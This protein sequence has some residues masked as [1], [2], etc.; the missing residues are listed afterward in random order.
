MSLLIFRASGDV[1]RVPVPATYLNRELVPGSPTSA[2]A[3][4]A[5]SPAS[6]NAGVATSGPSSPLAQ[7]HEQ[8]SGASGTTTETTGQVVE[9]DDHHAVTGLSSSSS[10]S[11]SSKAGAA[12]NDVAVADYNAKTND[13]VNNNEKQKAGSISTS[14]Q[15]S[16]D[17]DTGNNKQAAQKKLNKD[18]GG[19]SPRASS[20]SPTKG[21]GFATSSPSARKKTS[22]SQIRASS[23]SRAEGTSSSRRNQGNLSSPSSRDTSSRRDREQIESDSW[24]Q[25]Q[26]SRS[27]LHRT[28]RAFVENYWSRFDHSKSDTDGENNLKRLPGM[29]SSR[30]NTTAGNKAVDVDSQVVTGGLGGAPTSSLLGSEVQV[31]D[32]DDG[33][34]SRD[35]HVED[36]DSS[37]APGRAGGPRR[38]LVEQKQREATSD[39]ELDVRAGGRSGPQQVEFINELNLRYNTRLYNNPANIAGISK[40][41]MREI[42]LLQRS[43]NG[44]ASSSGTEDHDVGTGTGTDK[45]K[46]T[47][48]TTLNKMKKDKEG[49]G[50]VSEDLQE[51]EGQ[52]QEASSSASSKKKSFAVISSSNAS[53]SSSVHSTPRGILD[54][55]PGIDGPPQLV[56]TGAGPGPLVVLGGNNENLLVQRFGQNRGGHLETD[57]EEQD[58]DVDHEI[59]VA[60]DAR[61][62]AGAAGLIEQAL[63]PRI[64]PP[65]AGAPLNLGNNQVDY[66]GIIVNAATG[67]AAGPFGIHRTGGPEAPGSSPSHHLKRDDDEDQLHRRKHSTE[68]ISMPWSTKLDE[69]DDF[70]PTNPGGGSSSS[71]QI[72]GSSPTGGSAASPIVGDARPAPADAAAT[73]DVDWEAGGF[74]FQP[75]QRASTLPEHD[76]PLQLPHGTTPDV[77]L[78]QENGG[79]SVANYKNVDHS[80][81]TTA[82]GAGAHAAKAVQWGDEVDCIGDFGQQ[83]GAAGY[84]DNPY[85]EAHFEEST[86]PDANECTLTV[87][88]ARFLVAQALSHFDGRKVPVNLC[89]LIDMDSDEGHVMT[90]QELIRDYNFTALLVI[91]TKDYLQDGKY[92]SLAAALLHEEDLE[93]SYEIVYQMSEE[94]LNQ[95]TT[96]DKD[97]QTHI[98]YDVTRNTKTPLAKTYQALAIVDSGRFR[99]PPCDLTHGRDGYYDNI[100]VAIIRVLGWSQPTGALG[101]RLVRIARLILDSPYTNKQD[102]LVNKLSDVNETALMLAVRCRNFALFKLILEFAM[103]HDCASELVSIRESIGGHE[104]AFLFAAK[105]GCPDIFQFML[106]NAKRFS[107]DINQ[108]SEYGL[109]AFLFAASNNQV[110]ICKML[111]EEPGFT[112]VNDKCRDGCNAFLYACSHYGS[113][114]MCRLLLE[115]KVRV[116]APPIVQKAEQGGPATATSPTSEPGRGAEGTTGVLGLGGGNRG[117]NTRTSTNGLDLVADLA[118]AMGATT[119]GNATRGVVADTIFEQ[120]PTGAT[121]AAATRNLHEGAPAPRPPG[122]H[123]DVEAQHVDS[124]TGQEGALHNGSTSSSATP[125]SQ[126]LVGAT[127]TA[128]RPPSIDPTTST[129]PSDFSKLKNTDERL[130]PDDVEAS[131]ELSGVSAEHQNKQ[132]QVLPLPIPPE[133]EDSDI[134]SK[135]SGSSGKQTSGSSASCSGDHP[136]MPGIELPLEDPTFSAFATPTRAPR[137][138][139]GAGGR[140]NNIGGGGLLVLAGPS[141]PEVEVIKLSSKN[142]EAGG[143]APPGLIGSDGVAAMSSTSSE[144]VDLPDDVNADPPPPFMSEEQVAFEDDAEFEY[145]PDLEDLQFYAATMGIAP[146][147]RGNQALLDD[148]DAIVHGRAAGRRAMARAQ[149]AGAAHQRR[150]ID[151]TGAGAE[152][153]EMNEGNGNVTTTT[154]TAVPVVTGRAAP[155]PPA[156]IDEPNAAMNQLDYDVDDEVGATPVALQGSFAP[157]RGFPD[158]RDLRARRERAQ[159]RLVRALGQQQDGGAG[160]PQVGAPPDEGGVDN[161]ADA[162][163]TTAAPG[164]PA[165]QAPVPMELLHDDGHGNSSAC[166]DVG[167]GERDRSGESMEAPMGSG[168]RIREQA[169]AGGSASSGSEPSAGVAMRHHDVREAMM[170]ADLEEMRN[171]N[172]NAN[173]A[174]PSG[175]VASTPP[176]HPIGAAP[177]PAGAE[178][179]V[180]GGGS[181][182][183]MLSTYRTPEANFREARWRKR[184]MWDYERG[185]Y[186]GLDHAGSRAP[187]MEDVEPSSSSSATRPSPP[188][189]RPSHQAWSPADVSG[190]PTSTNPTSVNTGDGGASS[191]S[192][193]APPQGQQQ[194]EEPLPPQP[195]VLQQQTVL[196]R[197]RLLPPP[198]RTTS[199]GARD[200]TT[201][202]LDGVP[203]AQHGGSPVRRAVA[204]Q[205]AAAAKEEAERVLGGDVNSNY[206]ETITSSAGEEVAAPEQEAAAAVPTATRQQDPPGAAPAAATASI[207][208]SPLAG[209]AGG[210]PTTSSSGEENLSEVSMQGLPMATA[211]AHNNFARLARP[212]L[213][214]G[215]ALDAE[216]ERPDVVPPRPG[217]GVAEVQT[218]DVGEE[219]AAGPLLDNAADAQMN[220]Q[221]NI[222]VVA[223]A[224]DVPIV[225]GG[226][227]AANRARNAEDNLDIMMNNFLRNR[228]AGRAGINN[229]NGRNGN[230]NNNQDEGLQQ[231]RYKVVRCNF[232]NKFTGFEAVDQDGRNGFL[233]AIRSGYGGA[234]RKLLQYLIKHSD[235]F[236][237]GFL[238][239][240]D[241]DGNNSFHQ[242]IY[243]CSIETV[244]LLLHHKHKFKKGFI[245]VKNKAG[246]NA[247]LLAA[248]FSEPITR[249]L[250]EEEEFQFIDSS[251]GKMTSSSSSSSTTTTGTTGASRSSVEQEKSSSS[252][253]SS[254]PSPDLQASTRTTT[255]V[256]NEVNKEGVNAFLRAASMGRLDICRLLYNHRAFQ[257]EGINEVDRHGNNA[258][259]LAAGYGNI[260]ICNF[261]LNGEARD[262]FTGSINC[263]NKR[264]DTMLIVAAENGYAEF[265]RSLS[266]DPRF[267]MH[268]HQNNDGQTALLA[269]AKRGYVGVCDFFVS[270]DK[271]RLELEIADRFGNNAFLYAAASFRFAE[272]LERVFFNIVDPRNNGGMNDHD[273]LR[274]DND[275][276]NNRGGLAGVVGAADLD[277]MNRGGGGSN[278][279]FL[280]SVAHVHHPKVKVQSEHLQDPSLKFNL[281]FYQAVNHEG[282]NALHLGAAD[283]ALHI[284]RFLL[285]KAAILGLSKGTRDGHGNTPYMLLKEMMIKNRWDKNALYVDF[286]RELATSTD[287]D[288]LLDGGLASS[289]SSASSASGSSSQD[290]LGTR[291]AGVEALFTTGERGQGRDAGVDTYEGMGEL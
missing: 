49:T 45:E 184:Q 275:N 110:D 30:F 20:S 77:E 59:A 130:L 31:Q 206:P 138:M 270:S 150:G 121:A 28:Q 94:E 256:A 265:C 217:Q 14:G 180:L 236:G 160:G 285:R 36:V 32:V 283:G 279:N 62:A 192:S 135:K 281:S 113:L 128:R 142:T 262:V 26:L 16:V 237:P 107:I 123:G 228:G 67:Q 43:A 6:P 259:L 12:G 96:F 18:K 189:T 115:G 95:Y 105:E 71:T 177:P 205:N 101:D 224:V 56:G 287:E 148:A 82:R 103:R 169:A 197:E 97:V 158:E 10:A 1:M 264:G 248:S 233:R 106:K 225:V 85:D 250:L 147:D 58:V 126:D 141:A 238:D 178:G 157:F 118:N 5:S 21:L 161:H 172:R 81:F 93:T 151:T 79:R 247:L 209:V 153:V 235:K 144:T 53:G 254:K 51:V 42:T 167:Q 257:K 260:G 282:R 29:L 72:P 27:L 249:M 2:P 240:C 244:E 222:N 134:E 239:A 195:I 273:I 109:S 61:R 179:L 190:V 137:T 202:W 268:F 183:L 74:P 220:N 22:T 252:S 48:S 124:T 136:T 83:Q 204:E 120:V 185:E 50:V 87:R 23:S 186:A 163:G 266:A 44:S 78:G 60:D 114:Q 154:S 246:N 122:M 8:A 267:G 15:K 193:T 274:G 68:A 219:A 112:G 242:A 271:Y 263:T 214:G 188:E 173:G 203:I 19:P 46:E 63:P 69:D 13:Q 117:T 131:R 24:M 229:L 187:P 291:A 55:A 139:G 25:R 108:K 232:V 159:E 156:E 223:A 280:A 66:G 34:A 218:H 175:G 127:S 255:C 91:Q 221:E 17:H 245:S 39:P 288:D 168:L 277:G 208:S 198:S 70:P 201:Q 76:G 166:P 261:L 289:A 52:R 170:L 92:E 278:P 207:T 100:L 98:L 75:T 251:K 111:M 231:R 226:A 216:D 230:N 176:P 125:S 286:L 64:P 41:R 191:S 194:T 116:P 129:E 290:P 80:E 164:G 165:Q 269:A 145:S 196:E 132:K 210:A 33:T 241:K 143:A 3:S 73:A 84:V 133:H 9:Q 258:L 211:N 272:D 7:A 152:N 174:V 38:L 243:R 199:A 215:P 284:C 182:D 162:L 11:S 213:H 200:T 227:R 102:L 54:G 181:S 47:S 99:Y 90:D 88:E 276:I 119:G 104:T 4:P 149:A 40:E 86:F 140:V 65:A 35:Q 57:Q 234:T 146:A 253:S 89:Y 155:P 212:F 37:R 171:H